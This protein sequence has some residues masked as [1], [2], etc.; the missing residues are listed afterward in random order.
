MYNAFESEKPAPLSA[1]FDQV[2]GLGRVGYVAAELDGEVYM[3][4]HPKLETATTPESNFFEETLVNPSVLNLLRRR[5]EIDCGGVQYFA[6]G[7]GD[8]VQL[9]LP[10]GS[11]HLSIGVESDRDVPALAGKI[12]NLIE[13]ERGL[14]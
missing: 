4:A 12:S 7:Y 1:L 14:R 5:G 13:G 3:Q 8:F 11:G 2:F 9:T 6:V 10:Y